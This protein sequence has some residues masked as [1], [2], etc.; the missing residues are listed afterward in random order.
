MAGKTPKCQFSVK[1]LIIGTFFLWITLHTQLIFGISQPRWNRKYLQLFSYCNAVLYQSSAWD[2]VATNKVELENTFLKS[3][4]C[5][6]S[7]TK[8]HKNPINPSR[9]NPGRREKIKLNFYF[10]TSLWCL[11]RFYEGLDKVFW[12][13]TKK[14]ENKNLS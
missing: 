12:G 7:V 11:R 14:C 8:D 9:P 10:H 2:L 3:L 13:T 4:L 5:L 1:I 6:I